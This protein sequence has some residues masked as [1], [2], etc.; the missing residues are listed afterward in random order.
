MIHLRLSWLK[1]SSE[2]N[3]LRAVSF[4]FF[5]IYVEPDLELGVDMNGQ[6]LALKFVGIINKPNLIVFIYQ[7][8]FRRNSDVKNYIDEYSS[9]Y[10]I[11]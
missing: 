4:I 2:R 1:L 6:L 10:S 8:G 11:H 3:D 9:P 7:T 5:R